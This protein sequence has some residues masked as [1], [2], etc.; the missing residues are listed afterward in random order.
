[1]YVHDVSSVLL[2]PEQELRGFAKVHLAPGASRRVTI[3]LGRRAFAVWD[4]SSKA[5]KVEAGDFEV[6]VGASSRDIRHRAVVAVDSDD[7][8]APVPAAAEA[9]ATEAEFAKLLG[10]PLPAPR[11]LMPLMRDSAID[12]LLRTWLG[13]RLHGL[14]MGQIGRTFDVSEMDEQ[15]ATMMQAVIGQMPLRGVVANS[16]GRLS[17]A[18]L[19]KLLAVLNLGSRR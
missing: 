12:D 2:R 16:A 9:V 10:R 3:A 8:V 4:V 13:R 5:W 11:P 15:T 7:A 19:D 6:R 17:F 1:V 18:A 14:L